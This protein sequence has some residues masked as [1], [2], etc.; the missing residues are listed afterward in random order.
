MASIVVVGADEVIA[1]LTESCVVGKRRDDRAILAVDDGMRTQ[2]CVG[3]ACSSSSSTTAIRQRVVLREA[4]FRRLVPLPLDVLRRLSLFQV[5]AVVLRV[6]SCCFSSDAAERDGS[7]SL[8]LK[9]D[10]LVMM[11]RLCLESTIDSINEYCKGCNE[12]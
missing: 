5:E 9:L 2:A 3:G 12:E 8:P 1:A 11:I 7:L 4:C 10:N 6:V